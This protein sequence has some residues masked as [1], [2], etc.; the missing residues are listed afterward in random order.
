MDRPRTPFN[1]K[2]VGN[3]YCVIKTA[4]RILKTSNG[5]TEKT[6]RISVLKI[7]IMNS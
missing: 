5:N 3:N 6:V 2:E 1:S 4:G 7:T